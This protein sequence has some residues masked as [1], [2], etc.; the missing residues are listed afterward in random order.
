MAANAL[1]KIKLSVEFVGQPAVGTLV[2]VIERHH[3]PQTLNKLLRNLPLKARG[4]FY[5]RNDKI[6]M[7][8]NLGLKAG[9]EKAKKLDL[10]RGDI[11]YEPQQDAILF[12]L[13]PGT[14]PTI[15]NLLGQIESGT[16]KLTKE[17]LR[18]GLV[19]VFKRIK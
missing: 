4:R 18:N 15:V 10:N 16:E 12:A 1:E 6:F 8:H 17:N 13:E 7:A 19:L 9:P 2:A 14:T 11:V 5:I 3:S